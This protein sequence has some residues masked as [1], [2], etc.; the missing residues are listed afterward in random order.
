M[1]SASDAVVLGRSTTTAVTFSPHTGSGR[2][3]TAAS[4]TDG[5]RY[6]ASSTSLAHVLAARDDH[7]LHPVDDVE[8]ALLVTTCHVA[9]TEPAVLERLGRSLLVAEVA[10]QH[11]LATNHYLA[12]DTGRALDHVLVDHLHVRQAHGRAARCQQVLLTVDRSHMRR[13]R[14]GQHVAAQLCHAETGVHDGAEP[15]DA[16][17]RSTSTG[18]AAAP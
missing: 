16:R 1:I 2:P 12:D 15:F 14:K 17:V 3:T 13:L 8:E 4:A 5:C 9:G 11:L 18:M 6:S 10:L 7:V